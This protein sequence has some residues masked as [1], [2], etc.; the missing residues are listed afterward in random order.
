MRLPVFVCRLRQVFRC[1]CGILLPGG[2]RKVTVYADTL[3]ALNFGVDYLILL[4]T[5]RVTGAPRRRGRLAL[6]AL[7]GAVYALLCVLCPIAGKPVC[8]L[9]A[10]VLMVMA[11]IGKSH[12]VRRSLI[13]AGASAA[14]GGGVWALGLM[15]G[16]KELSPAGVFF[17]AALCCAVLSLGFRLSAPER[18]TR[19][20]WV[21]LERGGRQITFR[22]LVDTGNRLRGPGGAFV[23][24]AER[25]TLLPLLDARERRAVIPADPAG[26]FER[27]AMLGARPILVPF[28]TVSERG[29]LL[30]ALRP[31]R[32]EAEGR[33]LGPVLAAFAP[34]ELSDGGGYT[35][36][37]G[38]EILE[39][40]GTI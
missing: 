29:G 23:I 3:A 33:E 4:A 2:G 20:V 30:V 26:S 16:G 12:L 8:R 18:G 39:N 27:L 19:T 38:S 11:G 37:I 9:P 1:P 6:G 25:E 40:G 21:T 17:C 36:I 28:G 31:D 34:A 10:A 13:F 24:A 7:T 14:M 5:A 32:A 22:A 35:A 15:L